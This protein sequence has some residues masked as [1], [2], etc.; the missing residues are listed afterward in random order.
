MRLSTDAAIRERYRHAVAK[1]EFYAP[2]ASVSYSAAKYILAKDSP[3]KKTLAEYGV[4][5]QPSSSTISLAS[6]AP[7]IALPYDSMFD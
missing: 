2:T 6:A 3:Y 5:S 4:L 1:G 7:E